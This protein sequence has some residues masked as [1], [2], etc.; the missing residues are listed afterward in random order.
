M[1]ESKN[2]LGIKLLKHILM[3]T[4][5]LIEKRSSKMVELHQMQYEC[6]PV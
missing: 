1:L 6:R 4:E 2:Y 5:K 3:I